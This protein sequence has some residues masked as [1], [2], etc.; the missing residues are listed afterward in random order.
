[1]YMLL[2][3]DNNI[4][5]TVKSG[6]AA[7][8]LGLIS[9]FSAVAQEGHGYL[10]IETK[11]PIEKI[12]IDDS[13]YV[14]SGKIRLPAG[15]HRLFIQNPDRVSMQALDFSK[16]ITITPDADKKVDVY[17]EEVSEINSYP[18]GA[19]VSFN[20]EILGV[21]P[22]YLCLQNFKG[23]VLEFKK[24]G[25]ESLFATVT[26]SIIEKDYMYI[27]LQPK[28]INRSNNQN[29]FV[30]LEWQERG[31]H[32]YRNAIWISNGLGI[33]FGAYAAYYKKKA[34]D[35]F[36]KA[37]IARRLGDTPS[38]ERYLNKTQKFDRYAVI[39]FVGMQVNVA[40]LVYFLFKSR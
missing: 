21:T 7:M 16:T 13:V 14:N 27:E 29:Q 33:A 1:M 37:K 17:F 38:R 2:K 12:T 30:N 36:E 28:I 32:K 9:C 5:D 22:F 26:D 25:Y 6:V 8:L 15:V 4:R 18:S 35:A 20:S 23:Q 31:P 3:R 19:S 11:V 24:S 39:G 40:A 34:D 10:T